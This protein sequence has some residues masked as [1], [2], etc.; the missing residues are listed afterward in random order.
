VAE[1]ITFSVL[2]TNVNFSGMP[3]SRWRQ[4]EDARFDWTKVEART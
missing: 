1:T 3:N 2:L 4:F